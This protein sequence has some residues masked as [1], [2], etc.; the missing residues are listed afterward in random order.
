M[1]TSF[2]LEFYIDFKDNPQNFYMSRAQT[3]PAAPQQWAIMEHNTVS[4]Q[5]PEK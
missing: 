2:S 1:P 3:D 4:G 5:T